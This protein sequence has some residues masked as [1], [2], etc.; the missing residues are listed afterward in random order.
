M[1]I[2]SYTRRIFLPL[3]I[4]CTAVIP[5][6]GQTCSCAGAPLISAQ[7]M[8]ASSAGNL[9]FG[10]TVEHNEIS[11]VFAG[12][13]RL[14]NKSVSRATLSLLFESHYGLTDRLSIS[15]TLTTVRKERTTGLGSVDTPTTVT[16]QGIGDGLVMLR[17]TL[18][19]QSLWNRYHLAVGGGVKAPLG[20]ASLTR[21]GHPLNADMQPGTGAWDGVFWSYAAVSFLP[22]T[23]LN[24]FS[25]T[26]YRHSGSNERFGRGDNYRF[27]NE[28]ISALGVSDA[29]GSAVSYVLQFRYRSTS[30]DRLNG[31]PLFNTGGRWLSVLPALQ[32]AAGKRASLV[33]SGRYPLWQRLSGTQ[34]TT[35]FAVAV[36]LFLNFNS[37]GN[38]FLQGDP[39]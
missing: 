30:A 17:Y 24:L 7:S 16:T 39:R 12:R 4:F 31:N 21:S 38:G 19:K 35:T 2:A 9:V 29:L 27:G 14:D 28:L 1:L 36:S 32:I 18:L 37:Q 13:E 26:S 6:Q 15:A 20:S 22:H 3:L 25:T 11:S 33:V 8:G 23:T 5:S 34:P 10:V